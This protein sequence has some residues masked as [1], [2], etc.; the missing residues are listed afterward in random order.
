VTPSERVRVAYERFN[1]KDFAGVVE[2]FHPDAEHAD[3]LRHGVMHRGR[4]AILP[5]WTRRFAEASAHA[6][7]YELISRL[8]ATFID[9][10]SDDASALFLQP[11]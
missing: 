11:A 5:L 1:N 7:I 9:N 8:G 10:V 6:L 4:E 3:L 2:L